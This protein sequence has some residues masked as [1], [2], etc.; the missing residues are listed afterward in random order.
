MGVS[1]RI[2]GTPPAGTTVDVEWLDPN[3]KEETAYFAK[4]VKKLKKLGYET[5]VNLHGAPY[6]F[7]RAANEQDEYFKKLKKL[8]ENTYKENGKK[9][10][11]L[12][13]HSMGCTMTLYFLTNKVN[14]AWK[15]KHV[16]GIITLAGPWGGSAVALEVFTV[17]T[18]L[19]ERHPDL[20]PLDDKIRVAIRDVERT[21]PSLA[22][23]MPTS[24]IWSKD[25][26]VQTTVKKKEKDYT[27]ADIGEFFKLLGVPNMA[28]F[29]KEVQKL[30][31]KLP[32]PGVKVH[33]VYGSGLP[34][35]DQLIYSKDPKT[36]VPYF[37]KGFGDGTVNLK[38]LE[39]CKDWNEV[40]T[41]E[42]PGQD[43]MAM[44]T[45]SKVIKYV[46]DLVKKLNKE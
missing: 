20:D 23:M 37:N 40:K 8:I 33:C 18:D 41:K 14:K 15:N 34:T 1:T 21:Y 42:F 25:I 29:Y 12:I 6:D 30:T 9:P 4:M 7:R 26:L 2:P 24:Q 22:W 27:T 3:L 45:G 39:A 46:V 10:V 5:D 38:S 11:I 19:N 13:A 44:V 17:G 31:A 36:S 28:T 32:D 35:T 16:K 43:H